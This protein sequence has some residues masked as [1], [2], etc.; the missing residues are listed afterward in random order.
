VPSIQATLAEE[1]PLNVAADVMA[2]GKHTTGYYSSDQKATKPKKSSSLRVDT[3]YATTAFPIFP[4]ATADGGGIVLYALSRDAVTS[5][6]KKKPG[7]VPVPK[8][9]VPFLGPVKVHNEIDV[10]QTLQFAALVPPKAKK[11]ETQDRAVIIASDGDVIKASA[12]T[13]Q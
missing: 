10:T 13:P 4:L 12:P 11:G 8:E 7:R 1:G 3:V 2:A 6:S 9:A 5:K